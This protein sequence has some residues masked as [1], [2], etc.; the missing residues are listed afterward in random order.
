MS[1]VY[2]SGHNSKRSWKIAIFLLIILAVML[3]IGCQREKLYYRTVKRL[4]SIDST[5]VVALKIYPKV[6]NPVGEAKIFTGHDPLLNDFFQS[7]R[8]IDSYSPSHDRVASR[9]HSW[10]LEIIT[11]DGTIQIQFRIPV[12]KGQVVAGRIGKY[13][14]KRAVFYGWFQSQLL[15]QWYQKYK[16]RWLEPDGKEGSEE[17]EKKRR[18]EEQKLRN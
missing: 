11:K 15:F 1:F 3:I 14:Q 12:E 16:D 13:G 18:E 9:D 7:L 6:T 4:K 10:F 17:G 2:R 8:D 5:R